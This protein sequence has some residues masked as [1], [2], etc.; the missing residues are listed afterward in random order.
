MNNMNNMNNNNKKEK[1][2]ILKLEKAEWKVI[3]EIALCKKTKCSM[4]GCGI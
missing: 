4:H 1:S 2:A 3:D